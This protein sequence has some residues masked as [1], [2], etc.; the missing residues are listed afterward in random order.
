[1]TMLQA[2]AE[3]RGKIGMGDYDSDEDPDNPRKTT[4]P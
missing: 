4:L 2:M 1:M 3:V